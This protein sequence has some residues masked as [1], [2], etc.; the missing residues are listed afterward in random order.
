MLKA[1]GLRVCSACAASRFCKSDIS[2]G[3]NHKAELVGHTS[4][5]AMTT[6][7]VTNQVY[8]AYKELIHMGRAKWLF[9]WLWLL[10][11]KKYI[12]QSYK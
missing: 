3:L 6:T 10:T 12:F 9:T 11:L 8:C 7:R 2:K 4:Y 1:A 5:E